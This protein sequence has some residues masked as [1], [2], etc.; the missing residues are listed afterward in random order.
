MRNGLQN[1]SHRKKKSFQMK[2]KRGWWFIILGWFKQ[3]FNLS[4]CHSQIKEREIY[5]KAKNNKLKA[6][7]RFLSYSFSFFQKTCHTITKKKEQQQQQT[8]QN[9][10]WIKR[11]KSPVIQSRVINWFKQ[12]FNHPRGDGQLKIKYSLACE[13]VFFFFLVCSFSW[14][15]NRSSLVSIWSLRSLR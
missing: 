9:K 15:G 11:K 7:W 3:R 8:K 4:T 10:I 5:V 12:R 14:T 1:N 13:S 2:K 6:I